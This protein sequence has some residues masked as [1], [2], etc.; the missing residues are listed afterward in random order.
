MER[1][2]DGFVTARLEQAAPQV[3]PDAVATVDREQLAPVFHDLGTERLRLA[4]D[5]NHYRLVAVEL[6]QQRVGRDQLRQRIFGL[7]QVA[8][9]HDQWSRRSWRRFGQRQRRVHAPD[10]FAGV[11]L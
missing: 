10:V 8:R 6:A 4:V 11:G 7:V 3:Q 9:Q 5:L 2:A 1:V